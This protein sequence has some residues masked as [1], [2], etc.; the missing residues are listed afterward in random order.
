MKRTIIC[1]ACILSLV[2]SGV[3]QGRKRVIGR[4]ALNGRGDAEV[5]LDVQQ[6]VGVN[7]SAP[8]YSN[9][10]FNEAVKKIL[11]AAGLTGRLTFRFSPCSNI[12]NAVAV[13]DGGERYIFY[14]PDLMDKLSNDALTDYASWGLLAHEIGHQYYNHNLSTASLA[15]K[16][17]QELQADQF[18]GKIMCRL[19]IALRDAEAY[20]QK[21]RDVIDEENS[22]HPKN[23][24]RTDQIEAEYRSCGHFPTS[25]VSRSEYE[26]RSPG[27][28]IVC[29]GDATVSRGDSVD[30]K[31]IVNGYS[32]N[33]P[34]EISLNKAERKEQYHPGDRTRPP[35]VRTYPASG[36]SSP[37]TRMNLEQSNYGSVRIDVSDEAQ[38]GYYLLT[39][40]VKGGTHVAMHQC[41]LR[42]R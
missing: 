42:I 32:Y 25:S 3:A 38:S 17:E 28:N 20:I 33:G 8:G 26:T 2:F 10:D 40:S 24:K 34:V 4:C 12:S 6:M 23:K 16:R 1:V 5:C 30:Y 11:A 15:E 35:D 21:E 7:S 13:T 39:F 37:G 29:N 22:D 31:I 41:N 18:A 14:D 19:S 9:G 27:F 36:I